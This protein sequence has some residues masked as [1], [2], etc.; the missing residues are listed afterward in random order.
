MLITAPLLQ[1]VETA[2][3]SVVPA[4]PKLLDCIDD[5]TGLSYLN[6]P[7]IL[8]NLHQ[9]YL[10]D[11]IYTLAGPVLIAVNPLRAVRSASLL[12]PWTVCCPFRVHTITGL[13]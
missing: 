7:A 13:K 6:E 1:T 2:A 5:L 4:N 9:R 10:S 3:S 8:H 11:S 12:R